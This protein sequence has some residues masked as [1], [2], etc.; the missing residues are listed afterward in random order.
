M[1]KVK[2]TNKIQFNSYYKYN[3][4]YSIIHTKRSSHFFTFKPC[5]ISIIRNKTFTNHSLN[6]VA[7]EVYF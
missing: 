1:L 7:F 5:A 2:R 3:T 4:L 6:L